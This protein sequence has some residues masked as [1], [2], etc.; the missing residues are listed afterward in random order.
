MRTD[1][2]KELL[3]KL[4]EKTITLVELERLQ[5]IQTKEIEDLGLRVVTLGKRKG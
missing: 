2:H 1:E 4:A 3:K 5:A